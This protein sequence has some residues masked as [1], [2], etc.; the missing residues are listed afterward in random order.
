M[1]YTPPKNNR[2][3][4]VISI[5]LFLCAA[6]SVIFYSLNIGI[7][8]ILQL[9]IVIAV[10]AAGFITA[11]YGLSSYTYIIERDLSLDRVQRF[12]I[13]KTQANRRRIICDISL[14]TAI[15]VIPKAPMAEIHA[16][17]GRINRKFNYNVNMFPES[18]YYY[19]FD[20]NGDGKTDIIEFEGNEDFSE[21]LKLM[22]EE[23]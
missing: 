6:S 1:S 21:L 9:I 3:P 18:S 23:K 13:I 7:V 17:Y 11:R 8:L 16:K 22:A 2:P 5:L 15:A 19:I 10:S 4:I 14:T 12:K 20:Y